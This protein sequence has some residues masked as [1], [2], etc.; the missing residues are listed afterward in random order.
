VTT[1]Y[2]TSSL[3]SNLN[4]LI[5][6][7]SYLHLSHQHIFL[8]SLLLYH[9]SSAYVVSKVSI[10]IFKTRVFKLL[11]TLEKARVWNGSSFH[12]SFTTV[13]DLHLSGFGCDGSLPF[14]LGHTLVLDS[15]TDGWFLNCPL[16]GSFE[17][18]IQIV[19]FF[20]V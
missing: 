10:I 15:N 14:D 8:F 7:N 20:L 2:N 13:E 18:I 17:F 4:K 11:F 1:P 5:L 19:P 16:S 3:C 6:I 9:L 12:H